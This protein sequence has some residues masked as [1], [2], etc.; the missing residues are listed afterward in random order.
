MLVSIT[1]PTSDMILRL[2]RYI[3]LR[4]NILNI[5]IFGWMFLSANV[6]ELP[7]AYPRQK[8]I[9]YLIGIANIEFIIA[10]KVHLFH[11]KAFETDTRVKAT[12]ICHGRHTFD[13][14]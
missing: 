7:L 1:N 5:A 2:L 10:V 9:L 6:T 3:G 14:L 11:F 12:D 13:G 8:K 4:I